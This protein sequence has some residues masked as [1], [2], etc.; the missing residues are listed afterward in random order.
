MD[1]IFCM[2]FLNSR[3]VNRK[4]RNQNVKLYALALVTLFLAVCFPVQAQQ[5]AKVWKIGILVSTSHA[6]NASREDNL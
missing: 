1:E 4:S 5:P 3:T 2:R 6:L